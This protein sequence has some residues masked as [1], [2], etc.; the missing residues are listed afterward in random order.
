[1]FE[2]AGAEGRTPR[3]RKTLVMSGGV[4]EVV[5]A[6]DPDED[7]VLDFVVVT[8]L[9]AERALISGTGQER[10]RLRTAYFD[11]PC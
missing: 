2:V 6:L 11:C 5:D 1:V 10:S 3:L 4:E 8:D 7:G 9:G